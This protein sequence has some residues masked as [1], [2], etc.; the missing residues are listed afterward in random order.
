LS[1]P[2]LLR[3]SSGIQEYCVAILRTWACIQFY[4][5]RGRAVSNTGDHVQR[6]L[7]RAEKLKMERDTL[8]GVL[9][10]KEEEEERRIL[11]V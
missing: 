4:T 7:Y 1:Q 3:I 9:E 5:N 2:G 11:S 8:F 6:W 10:N